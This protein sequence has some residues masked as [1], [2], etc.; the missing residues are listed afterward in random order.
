MVLNIYGLLHDKLPFWEFVSQKSCLSK[1][2][3]IIGGDLNLSLGAAER[4]GP[5]AQDDPNMNFSQAFF[6]RTT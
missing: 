2:N 4:W 3:I 6:L 5:R 1:D